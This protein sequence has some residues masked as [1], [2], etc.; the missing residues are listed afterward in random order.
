MLKNWQKLECHISLAVFT[1]QNKQRLWN[2]PPI[3]SFLALGFL[4]CLWILQQFS[5]NFAIIFYAVDIF[6]GINDMKDNMMDHMESM[7]NV[8]YLSAISVG[9]IRIVGSVL[10]LRNFPFFLSTFCI[11]LQFSIPFEMQ[12]RPDLL[13]LEGQT[14]LKMCGTF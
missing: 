7:S 3:L 8:S 6:D 14:E 10:G 11:Q 12:S 13:F 5:G 2:S 4:I 9:A 1:L